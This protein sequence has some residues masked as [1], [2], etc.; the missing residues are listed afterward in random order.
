MSHALALDLAIALDDHPTAQA[1]LAARLDLLADETND[2]Y[3][4]GIA[5]AAR[6]NP[7]AV[8]ERA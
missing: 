3:L 4:A 6:R 2:R 1:Q 7:R 8:R 5:A